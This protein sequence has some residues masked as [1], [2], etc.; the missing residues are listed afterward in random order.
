MYPTDEQLEREF[1]AFDTAWEALRPFVIERYRQDIVNEYEAGY[2]VDAMWEALV[3]VNGPIDVNAR[4]A[5]EA[6]LDEMERQRRNSWE[7]FEARKALEKLPL[8]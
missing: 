7:V 8:K 3:H 1:D 4:Q 6:F 5:V 2:S